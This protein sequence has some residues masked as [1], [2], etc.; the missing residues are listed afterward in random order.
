MSPDFRPGHHEDAGQD[1][2][3][4]R[5][6]QRRVHILKA[7]LRRDEARAPQQAGQYREKRC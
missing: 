2:G 6:L 5:E 4:A 1:E 7:C 3:V